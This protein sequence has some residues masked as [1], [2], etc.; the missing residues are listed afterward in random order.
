MDINAVH[1]RQSNIMEVLEMKT[2]LNIT[3]FTATIGFALAAASFTATAGHCKSAKGY[4]GY[5][6]P[7]TGKGYGMHKPH[8]RMGY[9]QR[10]YYGHPPM[11]KGGYSNY[12]RPGYSAGKSGS[13]AKANDQQKAGKPG[14]IVSIASGSEDFETLVTAIKVAGLVNTLSDK[15]PYTVF[16]PTDE[17]FAKLPVEQL[18]A[19]LADKEALTNVLTY[20]VVPGTV[21]SDAASKL[22]SAKTV[23]GGTLIIDASDGVRING[24]KVVKADIQASNGVIHVIDTVILPN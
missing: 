8:P 23:Q 24:A 10:Q 7:Y 12:T 19:L 1:S 18:A 3:V 5:G 2:A 6:H 17:A 15:G 20:H 14:D 9:M 21:S 22:T 11:G 4:G 16:A 13:E